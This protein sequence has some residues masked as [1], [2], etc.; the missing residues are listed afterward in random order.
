MAAIVTGSKTVTVDK[1]PILTASLLTALFA[2]A[3]ENMTVAQ[4]GQ[5]IDAANRIPAPPT[6]TLGQLFQ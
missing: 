6:S 2:T 5:L 4:V 1:S 3:P